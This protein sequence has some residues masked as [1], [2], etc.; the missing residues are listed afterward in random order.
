MMPTSVEEGGIVIMGFF[1]P[2]DTVPHKKL[3][4]K[5][6]N[7]GVY[8]PINYCLNMILANTKIKTVF[9]YIMSL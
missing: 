5:M 7:C 1:K 8:G 6:G 3:L 9:V 2:F 4:L